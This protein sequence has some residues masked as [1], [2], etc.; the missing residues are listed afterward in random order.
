MNKKHL[1]YPIV[2]LSVLLMLFS[3]TYVAPIVK[4]YYVVEDTTE[5]SFFNHTANLLWY[6]PQ[7]DEF[8]VNDSLIA[9][10]DTLWNHPTMVPLSKSGW[11]EYRD[12]VFTSAAPFTVAIGDTVTLPNGGKVKVWAENVGLEI[13]N[14]RYVIK[15]TKKG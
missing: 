14:I 12:T 10:G 6:F 8:Y 4:G 15:R 5:T 7:V 13:Y 11:A 1:L 9:S 3:N 2:M